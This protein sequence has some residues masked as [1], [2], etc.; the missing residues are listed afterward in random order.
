MTT[1]T[2]SD[3]DFRYRDS[4]VALA[5]IDRALAKGKT[6]A[7]VA[8]SLEVTTAAIDGWRKK[9]TSLRAATARR[10]RRLERR[11]DK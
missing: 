2:A 8:E 11:L 6:K 5:I 4:I 10:V 7:E 3:D 9:R 1:E